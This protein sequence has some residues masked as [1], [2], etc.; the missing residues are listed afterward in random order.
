MQSLVMTM[1]FLILAASA[2]G[3]TVTP[4]P[5]S[6]EP[7]TAMTLEVAHAK[8]ESGHERE[9]IDALQQL[10]AAKP[11]VKGAKRELGIAYYRTAKL[12]EAEQSFAAALAEDPD[13]GR[14]VQMRGLTLYRLGRPSAALRY[15]ERARQWNPDS[16]VDVNYV[17]GRCYIDLHRYDDARAAFAAQYRVDP[18]T[19]AAYLILAQML[20]T[21]ELPETAE[22]N[23][24][25]A[26]RVSPN[27]ALAH[28]V[29]GK[30]YLAR[31]D[32]S[33]AL[34]QFEQERKINPA[35][36]PLYQFLADLYIKAGQLK[37]AQ[38]SLTEAISLDQSSTGPFILMGRVFLDEND[39]ET[40][41]SYLQ[42]A[43]QM[44][45]SNFITHYLLGRAYRQMGRNEEAKR[46]LDKVSKIHSA[47]IKSIQ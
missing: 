12:V 34:E 1:M 38:H 47:D 18:N 3:Q 26:L 17:V 45:S 43:E 23:A 35:Y 31:R 39:P 29:L 46:E 14:S 19:G 28:F 36:S 21:L 16:D 44:D 27:I 30:V 9:A 22:Q 4:S 20:L 40:A 10:V 2:Y 24:N 41:V 5:V 32:T 8:L 42:H 15:L 25:T 11:P 37:E 33:H 13:D 7:P 6:S